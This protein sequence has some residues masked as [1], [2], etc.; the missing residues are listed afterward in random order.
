MEKTKVALLFG[1]CS[2][3]YEVSL[4]SAYSII[5]NMDR[6]KY[7]LVL[8]GITRDGRWLRY[9]GG[10]EAIKGDFWEADSRCVPAFF[11][12][13]R[14]VRGLLEL[15][16]DEVV[17]T[18]IDVVFPV[19]HGK[20][21]EDGTLQGLLDMAGIPYVGC[22][23]FASAA[24]MDKDVAHKLAEAA[25]VT[26]PRSAA[27]FRRDDLADISQGVWKFQYPLYV[28]PA[29]GGSSI[30]ITRVDD[31]TT[32]IGA[33]KKAF[34]HDDKIV[35]EENI[36]GFE[37][38]CA[39][40]GS[41]NLILGAVDE[42]QLH[43]TVFDYKEKYSMA[44]TVHHVPARIDSEK[45]ERI[46]QAAVAVYRALGCRGIARIDFFLTPE[47]SVVF[48]EINTLPGF[49]TGSRYPK[50]LMEAG[51]GFSEILD[52]LIA[53]AAETESDALSAVVNREAALSAVVNGEAAPSAIVDGEA[54]SSG[55]VTDTVQD[56]KAAKKDAEKS[57]AKHRLV[58]TVEVAI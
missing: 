37:V 8:V 29:R 22:G 26:V 45:A 10:A 57:L 47:G 24:G 38:G 21:G 18:P 25:G 14:N 58:E 51:L 19:L 11:S 23:V 53:A 44:K 6:E 43:G 15:R 34:Q 13:D 32:L 46:R 49:T 30:G 31:P 9:F 16:K 48:N 41:E 2:V 36:P 33:V 52:R 17:T 5:S 56:G 4:K 7:E 55:A 54:A 35:I 12:P 1:G 27:F 20:N 3:E 39:L 40:L 28:K 50:M 42:L